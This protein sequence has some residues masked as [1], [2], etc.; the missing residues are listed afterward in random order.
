MRDDE[1]QALVWARVQY[2]PAHEGMSLGTCK[3]VGDTVL[4]FLKI[5]ILPDGQ[6]NIPSMKPSV[7]AFM[8]HARAAGQDALGLANDQEADA[9]FKG[10][11]SART[12]TPGE[13]VTYHNPPKKPATGKKVRRRGRR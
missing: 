11:R 9:I 5:P 2:D 13:A 10:L 1:L 3:Q 8:E 12:V 7:K 4:D 6:I